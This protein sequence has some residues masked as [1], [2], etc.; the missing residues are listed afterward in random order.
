MLMQKVTQVRHQYQN[1]RRRNDKE[2]ATGDIPK[3]SKFNI[4]IESYLPNN[5]TQILTANVSEGTLTN[6]MNINQ[7]SSVM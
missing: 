6:A 5:V 7:P 3:R 4:E 1:T 2:D